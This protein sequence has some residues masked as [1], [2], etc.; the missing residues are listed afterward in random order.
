GTRRDGFGGQRRCG[1]KRGTAT[2]RGLSRIGCDSRQGLEVLRGNLWARRP[3]QRRQAA[4]LTRN[5][6]LD[7]AT[8]FQPTRRDFWFGSL[9]GHFHQ[10][11]EFGRSVTQ[12]NLRALRAT[13]LS[14]D[15]REDSEFL[16]RIS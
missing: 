11:S 9:S 2:R 3:A 14:A 8:D 10:S 6:R 16:P 1:T 15:F 4:L 7:A 5:N 12:R 13:E